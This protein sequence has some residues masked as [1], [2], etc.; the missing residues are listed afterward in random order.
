[1]SFIGKKLKKVR[2]IGHKIGHAVASIARKGGK[3]LVR[4]SELGAKLA[5]FLQLIPDPRAQALGEALTVGSAIGNK[6]GH[7][8]ESVGRSGSQ[9]LEDGDN[10]ALLERTKAQINRGRDIQENFRT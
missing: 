10:K 1:M 3:T 2:K 6:V 4:A 5:P 8:S 9:Y 7:L